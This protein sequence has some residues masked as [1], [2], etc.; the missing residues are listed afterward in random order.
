MLFRSESISKGFPIDEPRP[1]ASIGVAVYVLRII[2]IVP[3]LGYLAFVPWFVCWI[4]YWVKISNYTT[5]I[6]N[7]YAFDFEK[8]KLKF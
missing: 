6:Q 7:S 2:S 8:D 1:A 5:R 4:I 3:C